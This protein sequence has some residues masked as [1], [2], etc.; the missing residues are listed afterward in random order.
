MCS[1][2]AGPGVVGREGGPHTGVHMFQTCWVRCRWT[3]RRTAYRSSR[4][5]DLLGE[6]SLDEKADRIPEF[7]CSRL[8]GRGVV[9]REG[10]PHTGVRV[11][12]TCWVRCR[13][14]RRRTAYRSSRVLGL[15]GEVSL[16]EKA[17]RIQEFACSRL[18]G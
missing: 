1:R 14:T 2:L 12:Q 9:G 16:V 18:A 6:V 17:D 4:V 15:L 5:P 10:G 11:F 7:M 13:R 3:R 8:A